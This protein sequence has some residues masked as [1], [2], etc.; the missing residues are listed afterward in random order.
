MVYCIVPATLAGALHELLRAF[1]RDD[2]YVEVVVERRRGERRTGQERRCPLGLAPMRE[3]RRLRAANGRRVTEQRAPT[4]P[5]I[6]P[7][8]P[9]EASRYADEILFVE[10]LEPS[11]L[12][13]EDADTARLVVR[14]QLGEREVFDRL[15][16][17]YFDRVYA[18]MKVTLQDASEA[19][20]AAQDVFMRVLEALPRYERRAVPFRAWLFR[21]VRNCAINRLRQRKRLR[22]EEPADLEERADRSLI[23]DGEAS[24][25]LGDRR[26]L[27]L[28]EQLPLAQRQVIVLRYMMQFRFPEIATILERSPD[29]VRQLHQRA[30]RFLRE[31]FVATDQDAPDPRPTRVQRESMLRRGNEAPVLRQRRLALHGP[32]RSA[33]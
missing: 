26:L 14:F 30:L 24:S 11:Q 19:E 23:T 25:W 31:H 12:K 6:A 16:L 32:R 18:Y 15:Y 3:R 28:V 2:P 1:Y 8:L 5:S 17:R 10:R 9:A 21:I 27:A 22:L 20:D 33:V 13:H 7:K 29:A 4:A